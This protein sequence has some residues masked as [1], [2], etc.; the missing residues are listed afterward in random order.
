M[1]A[2][3]FPAALLVVFALGA[4]AP[5]RAQEEKPVQRATVPLSFLPP[6]LEGATY[7]LGI[8]D[9]KTGKLVRH[10]HEIA[11]ESAFTVGLN[12]LMTKWDGENDKGEPVPPGRYTARGF[13]V[14]PLKV[15][16]VDIL[17]NDWA[18]ND[19]ALRVK[20]V[21]AIALLPT[22]DGLAALATMADGSPAL[23]RFS[24]EGKLLWRQPVTGLSAD[25]HCALSVRDNDIF[26]MPKLSSG[27]TEVKSAG[28][29][30]IDG[31]APDPAQAMKVIASRVPAD[32]AAKFAPLPGIVSTTVPDPDLT[33]RSGVGMSSP[34]AHENSGRPA[35][36][37][38]NVRGSGTGGVPIWVTGM[39]GLRQI[40]PDG[41]VLRKLEVT[42][43]DPWPV[44]VSA[45]YEGHRL[46]LLEEKKGWQRL[47]G[48]SWLETKEEDGKQISTWQTFFER[49][50]RAPDPA[51]GLETPPVAV[52]ISLVD[53]PLDPGKPQ[54]VK[55]SAG[56]DA[57]GSYLTA[58]DGLRLRQISQR[59]NLQAAKLVRGKTANS[60]TFY[61]TDGSAWDEFSIQGARN[62]MAFDAGEFEMTAAGEKPVTEKAPEPPDL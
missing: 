49:N 14:G 13:A 10:L 56:F 46:Y 15:T 51:L 62:M 48:L 52:E 31:G 23:L 6:P 61:E 18:A 29:F 34:P 42:A 58:A 41:T 45:S 8:Y 35:I 37:P 43:G 27:E 21:E 25:A 4:V 55:L 12:G 44:D 33:I 40:G 38:P 50:I 39:E 7:S 60:L 22:D 47:R 26:V 20:H 57:K 53:N 36:P 24:V 2:L 3:L 54:K 16:G 1:H 17:G 30:K 5:V 32:L 28:T 19:E 59:A 9:A 11:P